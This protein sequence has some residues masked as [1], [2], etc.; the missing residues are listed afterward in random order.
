MMDQQ[1]ALIRALVGPSLSRQHQYHGSP[2]FRASI[3]H[4]AAWLPLMVDAASTQARTADEARDH[5]TNLARIMGPATITMVEGKPTI[6]FE[7]HLDRLKATAEARGQDATQ[8][9]RDAKSWPGAPID[10]DFLAGY[11]IDEATPEG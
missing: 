8:L 9:I 7:D 10:D 1:Q 6:N 11:P 5:L 2:T 3:N 4:L